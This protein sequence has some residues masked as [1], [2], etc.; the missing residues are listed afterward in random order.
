MTDKKITDLPANSVTANNDLVPMVDLSG[1]VTQKMTLTQLAAAVAAYLASGAVD[2]AKLTDATITNAK[3]STTAGEL[4]GAWLPYTPSPTGYSG[5]PTVTAA[6]YHQMGK[7]VELDYHVTGTSNSTSA[8]FT[9][10]VAPKSSGIY[11]T[12]IT[13]AG[14]DATTPGIAVFTAGSTSVALYKT[15]AASGWTAS[16]TKQIIMYGI[17]YEAN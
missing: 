8:G 12:R 5:T 7:T 4:G 15:A 9:L 16:G 10:P 1:N 2:A 3:L 13:D 14:T 11:L 17:K 6:R